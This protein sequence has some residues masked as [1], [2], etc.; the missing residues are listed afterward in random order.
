MG[1][2]SRTATVT[3]S[4]VD[5][6][7]IDGSA[8]GLIA[9]WNGD[10]WVGDCTN[11][12]VIHLTTTGDVVET[13]GSPGTGNGQFD[14][15][16]DVTRTA[17]GD[18]L[19]LD[20][21]NRRVQRLQ[22]DGTFVR[23]WPTGT[24]A[25]STV[26]GVDV[27]ADDNVYV[28]SSTPSRIDCT[29]EIGGDDCEVVPA[30]GRVS[31]FAPDGTPLGT[32]GGAST[33]R[34]TLG[35][36]W[37]TSADELFL[38]DLGGFEINT[39][40]GTQTGPP[41]QNLV[42]R[43]VAVDRFGNVWGISDRQLFQYTRDG[44]LLAQYELRFPNSADGI[45]VD[46]DFVYVTAGATVAKYGVGTPQLDVEV[47]ADRSVARP[48]EP[49]LEY[50]VALHNSGTTVLTG[51][52]TTA[53]PDP[54]CVRTIGDLLPDDSIT[55]TCPATVPGTPGPFPMT[56]TADTEET[57]PVTSAP[58][59]VTID[60]TAIVGQ[61][62]EAGSGQPISGAIVLALRSDTLALAGGGSSDL[63]GNYRVNVPPG[64]YLLQFASSRGQH[65]FEWYD[66]EPS[67]TS[68]G[69]LTPV[70]T[71]QDAT[72]TADADLTRTGGALFGTV[73]EEG[74]GN[75]VAGAYVIA[76]RDGAAVGRT[77]TAADGS[78]TIPHLVPGSYLVVTLDP[79]AAH[80]PEF[81]AGTASPSAATPVSIAAD[82]DVQV[83]SS[84]LAATPPAAVGDLRGKV[85]SPRTDAL[86]GALVVALRTSDLSLVG[87]A[88]T[89]TT[90]QFQMPV[91]SGS[92]YLQTVDPSGGHAMEWYDDLASPASFAQL[93]P[94]SAG[95]VVQ[96]SLTPARGQIRA[97]VSGTVADPRFWGAW[98]IVTG[99]QGTFGGRFMSGNPQSQSY[100]ISGLPAGTYQVIFIDPSNRFRHEFYDDA[101]SAATATPVSIP[102]G[103]FTLDVTATLQPN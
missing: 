6:F 89:D 25:Q 21:G 66:D 1:R 19:V 63:N 12:R 11:D 15:P 61:V 46:H 56:A 69:A 35:G 38:A 57:A 13:F 40:T 39:L 30:S 93:T 8:R 7:T 32:W 41:G 74:T 100:L 60:T 22:A 18:L 91:P 43:D 47:T 83:D 36:L 72:T 98:V 88:L 80:Q 90:G 102:P 77:T 55:L 92:F 26:F 42:T 67:P 2:A 23:A 52:R 9:N 33:G 14:C 53:A 4:E 70:V 103:P 73:T 68:F 45:T 27:D 95:A 82:T 20:Q 75:P 81:H 85:R 50:R 97:T 24:T 65:R 28:T 16:I 64:S 17:A 3:Y 5:R 10:L 51:V 96:V 94:V 48:G 31:R 58:E 76:L 62:A 34:E 44:T 87:A 84:L 86:A 99:P 101:T 59:V 37:I 71:T 29:P 78:Y 49:S 79:T 54:S